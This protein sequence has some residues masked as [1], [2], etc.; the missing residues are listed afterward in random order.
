MPWCASSSATAIVRPDQ[1]AAEIR[2]RPPGYRQSRCAHRGKA[3]SQARSRDR[4]CGATASSFRPPGAYWRARAK[5][6]GPQLARHRPAGRQ[7]NLRTD[8]RAHGDLP[9][10]GRRRYPPHRL[11][12]PADLRDTVRKLRDAEERIEAL[13]LS[14]RTNSIRADSWPAPA[15]PAA[16]SPLRIPSATP[17][18]SRAGARRGSRSTGR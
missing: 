11:A 17:K 9:R 8:A 1:G 15:T 2:H 5:A 14:T 18:R 6:A 13:G 7:D 10:L 4:R 16:S 12:E 3:R